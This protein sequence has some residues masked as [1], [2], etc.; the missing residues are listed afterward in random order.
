MAKYLMAWLGNKDLSA[1]NGAK[2][3]GYGPIGQAL[4]SNDFKFD[5]VVLISDHTEKVS[6]NY[7]EWLEKQTTSFVECYYEKL[8]S[9][10]NYEEIYKADIRVIE[11]I[12]KQDKSAKLVFH[13]S[14]GTPAMQAIWIILAKT[15]FD[16]ELIESSPEGGV[17][18]PYIPFEIAAEFVPRLLDKSDKGFEQLTLGK[19]PDIASFS[20][21]IHQSENM[22]RLVA[23]AQ[24]VALSSFSVLIEGESGTGKELFA[25][26]IHKASPRRDKKFIPVNCGAISENLIESELFGHIKGSFTGATNNRIGHFE[27]A[28]G[29]TIFLDEVGELPLAA[30]VKL[31]RVL[32][33]KEVV[34]VGDSK[35]KKVDVRVIAATNR[36]LPQM[37]LNNNFRE[38]LYFRLATI[39]LKIPALR[40]RPGDIS[41][42]IDKIFEKEIKQKTGDEL[43]F[44][45][46][47]LSVGA[48]NLLLQQTWKGNVRELTNV[49]AKSAFWSLKDKIEIED[50]RNALNEV[51]VTKDDN[52]LDK[53]LGNGF[54]L[55]D[56]IA[57]VTSHY[58]RRAVKESNGNKTIATKL[59]GM[60]NYQTFDNWI[61]KYNIE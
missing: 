15:R 61:K 24:R 2:D 10:T 30:Q 54:C 50:V 49:L 22:K 20:D 8:S 16:A 25:K 44:K 7:K 12:I 60:S 17:K 13:I 9:P 4:K 41:L 31:L 47:Y 34:K 45:N 53:P 5:K 6:S 56:L 28:D 39:V 52:I 14:P 36:S 33:E 27:Q 18:T 58:L 1:S 37:I 32:Q 21:I 40:E 46:K 38:D 43:G 11:N 57:Q 59:L 48:K 42:L 29:G 3:A 51:I 26:A 23:M 19:V 35:P 55:E